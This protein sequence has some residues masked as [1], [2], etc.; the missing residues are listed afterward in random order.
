MKVGPGP[1]SAPSR[2]FFFH[3]LSPD[4]SRFSSRRAYGVN[5]VIIGSVGYLEMKKESMGGH[6]HRRPTTRMSRPP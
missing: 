4:R 1:P 6:Q 2:I 3:S 5:R